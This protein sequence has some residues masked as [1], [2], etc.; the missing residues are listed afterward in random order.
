MRGRGR[1]IARVPDCIDGPEFIMVV[2]A[3]S[4]GLWPT[5]LPRSESDAADG[6]IVGFIRARWLLITH[7]EAEEQQSRTFR[8]MVSLSLAGRSA[9]GFVAYAASDG[10]ALD[11][12]RMPVSQVPARQ[13]D[14]ARADRGL[15]FDGSFATVG[16]WL[17]L[18]DD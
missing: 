13:A 15:E 12:A 18:Q 9:V 8:D 11:A 10:I 3:D 7:A 6:S 1:R 14:E 16:E 5:L 2:V 4:R 17:A